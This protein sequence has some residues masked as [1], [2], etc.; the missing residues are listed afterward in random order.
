LYISSIFFE[1]L[2]IRGRDGRTSNNY[3]QKYCPV[4]N[5][6][7]CSVCLKFGVAM[8]EKNEDPKM[9]LTDQHE[10]LNDPLLKK[11]HYIIR[12]SVK[13]LSIIMTLVILWGVIDVGWVIYKRLIEP[14]F[15]LL[16]ISDIL[17]TF[18]AFI[19]VMIAIEIFENITVY[20]REDVIHV[21]IVMATALMAIARKVIVLDYKELSPEYIYATAAVTLAMSIGY[22]LVVRN[23]KAKRVIS[24]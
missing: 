18:G 24:G 23:K 9:K 19:A 16:T 21:E 14:P 12:F 10:P 22:W 1:S 20:L 7:Y 2:K 17:T 4:H 15:L 11:L 13:V 5:Q 6:K 8:A 3:G